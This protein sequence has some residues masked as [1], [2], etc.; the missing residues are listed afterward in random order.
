MS[1]QILKLTLQPGV[2]AAAFEQTLRDAILPKLQI[3][4]RNVAGQS[5]RLF[6]TDQGSDDL[7]VY[8]VLV[9]TQL[10]GSTP[11]TAG[12]GPIVLCQTLLPVEM[13]VDDLA[14]LATITCMT[15]I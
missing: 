11:E 10:V 8:V 15:E 6:R 13:I 2:D 14:H 5:L 9:F 1:A 7:R 3:L 12:E 4:R